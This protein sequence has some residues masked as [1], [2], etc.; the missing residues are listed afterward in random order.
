MGLAPE[1]FATLTPAEFIQAWLGWMKMQR[2][3]IIHE[4]ELTRWQTWTLTSIQ[5]DRK[6]RKPMQQMFPMPW[7]KPAAGIPEEELSL[8]DRQ[9]RV[10]EIL[11]CIEH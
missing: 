2:D 1:V 6:D 4:W 10:K 8:A 7:D 3:R 9:E 5:L 11:K